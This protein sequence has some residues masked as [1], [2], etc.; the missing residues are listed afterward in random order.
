[1]AESGEDQSFR[2]FAP[3]WR[4]CWILQHSQDEHLN[5]YTLALTSIVIQY[6]LLQI[7]FINTHMQCI[8]VEVLVHWKSERSSPVSATTLLYYMYSDR[9]VFSACSCYKQVTVPIDCGEPVCLLLVS[10]S[11]T[12]HQLDY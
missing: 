5:R 11:P 3:S 6:R 12:V 9:A 1:M 7:S 2:L 10:P 4:N 8:P